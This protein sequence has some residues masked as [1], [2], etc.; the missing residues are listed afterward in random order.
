M[1]LLWLYY[2]FILQNGLSLIIKYFVVEFHK[3]NIRLNK[4]KVS[5]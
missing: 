3:Y 5:Q 1:V 4:K 2:Y